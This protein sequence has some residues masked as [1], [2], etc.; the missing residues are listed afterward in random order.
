[1]HGWKD[2]APEGYTPKQ[3]E[4][5]EKGELPVIVDSAA[6]IDDDYNDADD[7]DISGT[8]YIFYFSIMFSYPFF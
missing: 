7:D 8:F 6:D 1:M 3:K 2:I 5:Q 4:S